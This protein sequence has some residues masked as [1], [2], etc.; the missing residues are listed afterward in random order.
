[1]TTKRTP[2]RGDDRTPSGRTS[3]GWRQ[4][5]V[6]AVLLASTAL[7]FAALTSHPTATPEADVENRP[8]QLAQDD[9]VSS[10]TCRA[11]HPSQHDSWFGSFH[12]TMTQVATAGT[13]RADF[14]AVVIDAVPGQPMRLERRG[15]EFW[16]EF[17]DPGW[18]GPGLESERP[19]ITRQVVMITGSHHQQIYWYATG[20]DRALN[21]L[22]GVFL[23]DDQRWVARSA[24]VLHSPD[25]TVATLDGHWNAICV[26]CHTT[27]PKTKFATP[28]RSEP[29]D[30]QAVDTT[31]AE[32]GI[33]CEACHGPGAEHVRV[34]QNPVRRYQQHMADHDDPTIVQPALLDPQRSSEVCGQCHSVWEFYGPEDERRANADGFAYRPGDVLSETRFIAQPMPDMDSP[35]IAEFLAQDPE[36]VRGSFWADGMVRVSGREYNGLI[37]SPCFRDATEPEHTLTCFSCHTM[38]KTPE[39]RRS[40]ATWADTHQ[41]SVGMEGNDACLQCHEPIATQLTSHTNHAVDSSGSECYNCH[42]P[43]TSYGLLKAVRSHTISSPSATETVETGRPNACNLCHLDKTLAWTGEALDEWYGIPRPELD[44]DEA[45]VAAALLGVLRGDAGLRALTAWNLGWQPAQEAAGTSWVVP[46]LAELLNDPYEAVRYIAYRSL[47]SL[48]GY[49]D[50]RYDYLAS[51]P[52]RVQRVVPVIQAWRASPLAR[53]RREPELLVDADGNLQTDLMRRLFDLR[54]N[55]RLFLRE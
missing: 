51:E 12:R 34:N 19:R 7:G 26:A 9:F 16:A 32:F 42:M 14:D 48:P 50:F 45:T 33:S 6:I 22:P 31:T 25:Q 37:D 30:Q 1:M 46:H 53:L 39:D 2:R 44:D 54:D 35:A 55:R 49:G 8:I 11:C 43:Y 10:R 15:A 41:V 3:Q 21:V 13:V 4:T 5:P 27:L 17:D 38:H 20:H 47:R 52:D 28:F 36:F 40:V 23:L 29:I 24:V 18:E